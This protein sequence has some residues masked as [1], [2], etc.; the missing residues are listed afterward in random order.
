MEENPSQN[1]IDTLL[2]YFKKGEKLG[3]CPVIS[4]LPSLPLSFAANFAE[5][6]TIFGK[7][8]RSSFSSHNSNSLVAFNAF[9]ENWGDNVDNSLSIFLNLSLSLSFKAAPFLIKS[10]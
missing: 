2:E 1:D 7:P 4:H 6:I 3:N 9:F 10:L 8:S 5:S